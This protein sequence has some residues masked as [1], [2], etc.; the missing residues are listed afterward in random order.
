MAGTGCFLSLFL[1]WDGG[2]RTGRLQLQEEKTID[3]TMSAFSGN[4]FRNT[5]SLTRNLANRISGYLSS[6][7]RNSGG[8]DLNLSR[9]H[10]FETSAN[11]NVGSSAV[12]PERNPL[13]IS[14]TSTRQ[15]G[16]VGYGSAYGYE[17]RFHSRQGRRNTGRS[18]Y[19]SVSIAPSTQYAP[20]Y[21]DLEH[22]D[23]GLNF[24]QR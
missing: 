24:A 16:V 19:R 5:G 2:V 22:S 21:D 7:S 13:A 18:V 15:S 9:T 6:P 23:K 12:D 14:R 1:G 4:G 11:V 17:P 10:T 3:S 20:D 8:G